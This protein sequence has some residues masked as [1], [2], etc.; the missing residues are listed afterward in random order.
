MYDIYNFNNNFFE[1]RT[2]QGRDAFILAFCDMKK[3]KIS[4]TNI[5]INNQTSQR[6]RD[7]GETQYY[8]P[9]HNNEK[10]RVCRTF[11]LRALGGLGKDYVQAV[12]QSFFLTGSP[13]TD[14]R[15][16]DQKSVKYGHKRNVFKIFLNL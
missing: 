2:K 14:R 6:K 9:D 7:M 10:Q 15:G 3:K 8:I 4:K 13:R 16:G 11:F 12:N 5:I 1:N